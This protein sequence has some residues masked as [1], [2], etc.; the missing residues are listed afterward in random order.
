[1]FRKISGSSAF[2][3]GFYLPA[4]IFLFLTLLSGVWLRYQWT[5]PGG[6]IFRADFLIHGHSHVALLGWVFLGLM[7][8]TLESGTDRR[9][10]PFRFTAITGFLTAVTTVLLFLAFV[11]DGYAPASIILSTI[12]MIL[13]YI[14]AGIYFRCTSGIARLADRHFLD[15]AVFWMILATAGT[16]MLAAGQGLSPFWMHVSVRFYLHILF[17]GWFMFALAGFACRYMAGPDQKSETWPFWLMTA[18]LLPSLLPHLDPGRYG[19]WGFTG[20]LPWWYT[21]AGTAGTLLYGIGGIAVLFMLFRSGY[22]R[23][24]RWRFPILLWT[25]I[26]GAAFVFILP[27]ITSFPAI[28]G[29]WMQS[30]FLVIGFI[31]LHLLVTVTSLLLFMLLNRRI[32]KGPQRYFGLNAG[33]FLFTT[34]NVAMVLLLFMTGFFQIAGIL[35]PWP[36]QK[37]L[38]YTGSVSLTGLG[39]L[40]LFPQFILFSKRL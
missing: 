27:V 15:G 4:L 37:M 16:W 3:S 34:G 31:H 21:M 9:R 26:A 1:M 30:D 40:L 7:G 36:V 10:L 38:F 5:W 23:S 8:M 2:N 35:P 11:R 29:I 24:V 20:D 39:M 13:G 19:A 12:H 14:L 25:G 28:R 6:M 22:I 33:A 17:F 18:G 32:I